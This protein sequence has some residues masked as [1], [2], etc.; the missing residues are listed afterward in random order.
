MRAAQLPGGREEVKE[1]LTQVLGGW[2]KEGWDCVKHMPLNLEL[3]F[4]PIRL[5]HINCMYII[6]MIYDMYDIHLLCVY[7][8]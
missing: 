4:K 8:I 2:E 7:I 1:V 5:L 6:H 3:Q